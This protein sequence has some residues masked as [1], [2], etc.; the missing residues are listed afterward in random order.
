MK[1]KKLKAVKATVKNFAPFG[2]Y[3]SGK[4][5]KADSANEVFSWWHALGTV[6][7]KGETS[8]GIV[9][10]LPRE[11]MRENGLEHH[12]KTAEILIMTGDVVIVA[13]LGD[14]KNPGL[15]DPSTVRAF[16]VP[17]GDAVVFNPNVWHHAALAVKEACNVY[18]VFDKSTPDRDFYYVDLD[19]QFGFNWEITLPS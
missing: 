5:R 16:I 19:K 8:I 18:V 11:V 4:N 2:V 17:R 6:K 14:T 15:P 13:A 12:K 10:T 3:I 9:K 1:L 7:I